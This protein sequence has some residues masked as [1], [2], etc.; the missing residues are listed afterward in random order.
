MV[1][2]LSFNMSKRML[3]GHGNE[4]FEFPDYVHVLLSP[5]GFGRKITQDNQQQTRNWKKI[6]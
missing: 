2:Q 4:E 3:Y 1:I 6:C 5:V